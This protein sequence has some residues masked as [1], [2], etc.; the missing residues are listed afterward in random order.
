[1][2]FIFLVSHIQTC[3]GSSSESLH[4][5]ALDLTFNLCGVTSSESEEEVEEEV[6]ERPVSP[7]PLQD[8]PNSTTYY[9]PHPVS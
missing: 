6:E 9:D 2:R 7:E 4:E 3:M 5:R 8:S 1:M